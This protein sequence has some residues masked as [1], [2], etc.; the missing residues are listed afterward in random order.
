MAP[1]QVKG[2]PDAPDLGIVEYVSKDERVEITV[3]VSKTVHQMLL[4]LLE[5]GLYGHTVED[6]ADRLLC[7]R[8][9]CEIGTD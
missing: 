8:L 9:R 7:E 2:Q 3:P 4:G 6:V 5:T 1:P